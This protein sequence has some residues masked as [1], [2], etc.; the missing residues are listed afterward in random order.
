MEMSASTG[1]RL[2]KLTPAQL[3]AQLE[4]ASARLPAEILKAAHTIALIGESAGKQNATTR[5][6]T[7]T[8]RLRGSVFGNVEGSTNEIKVRVG[9]GSPQVTYAR[10][11]DAGGVVRPTR[12]EYLRIPLP[13]ALTAAGVDRFATPL[14][15]T[16]PNKFYAARSR[17]GNLLL[18]DRETGEP[19]Y[20][21]KKSITIRATNFMRDA[22]KEASDR[23]P[24]LITRAVKDAL[25]G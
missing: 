21:L 7:R 18:F 6:K 20:V 25:E 9:A 22:A 12:G 15:A 8:G 2:A 17:A 3:A 24:A 14:R 11:Q 13:A 4:T 19:F 5:L 10:I 23:A 1:W 16:A